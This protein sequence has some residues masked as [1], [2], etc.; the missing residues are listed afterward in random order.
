MMSDFGTARTETRLPVPRTRGSIVYP[1]WRISPSTTLATVATGALS[2]FRSKP[3]PL[4]PAEDCA[5]G[6]VTSV[7]SVP[8]NTAGWG[9]EPLDVV[10]PPVCVGVRGRISIDFTLSTTS[11][12]VEAEGLLPFVTRLQ[13]DRR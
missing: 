4:P 3:L 11:M 10:V 2:K 1:V 13:D 5:R 6:A 9:R 12:S 8:W 7:I